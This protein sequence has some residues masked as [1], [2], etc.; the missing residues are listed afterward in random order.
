[1]H[2]SAVIAEPI[3]PTQAGRGVLVVDDEEL[4]RDWMVHLLKQNGEAIV[5]TAENG[6][7]ALALLETNG[8][9]IGLIICDL[10]MPRMDG[11]ALLRHMAESAYRPAIVV[12]SNVDSAILRGVELMAKALGHT[13][14]GSLTKPI[15]SSAVQK[16]I[17]SYR[18]LKLPS[19]TKTEILVTAE[20]IDR[21]MAAGEF[22]AYFQPKVDLASG[23]FVGVE[24]LARWQHPLHGVLRPAAF[25]PTIEATGKDVQLT[26]AIMASAVA[27]AASWRQD[28]LRLKLNLFCHRHISDP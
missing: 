1:M 19:E 10:Q 3:A 27:A 15:K 4:H 28:G 7:D 13:V 8:D 6:P 26:Q 16:V 23:Q 12:S 14:V 5:H 11:M 18:G 21:G 17:A 22:V 9:D 20:D 24:A 25:M 2:Q